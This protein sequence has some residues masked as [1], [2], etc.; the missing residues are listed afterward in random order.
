MIIEKILEHKQKKYRQAPVRSNRASEL[1]HPCLRYLVLNRLKWQEK[2]LPP[3]SKLL[4]YEEGGLHEQKVIRDIQDAG[5]T[6]I[7][8]QRAFEW[9]EYEITGHIDAKVIVQ[10]KVY[11]LEVKTTSPYI[12]RTIQSAKDLYESKHYWVRMYPAQM[13]IYLLLDNKEE[14]IFIFKD[15]SSGELKEIVFKLDYELGE[16]LLQKAEKVNE[17]VKREEIPD[18]IEFDEE[19]C[20]SCGFLHICLPD[21]KREEI[22]LLEDP[23]LL[24]KLDRWYELKQ[25]LKEY[26]ELDKQIKEALKGKERVVLGSFLITGKWV[27]RKTYEVPETEYWQMKIQRISK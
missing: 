4:L 16:E 13:T 2:A 15:K 22:L 20:G 6:V 14:G 9:R 10:E 7:E 24:E 11:P 25:L 27:K 3:I 26:N 12:F 1:G 17:Y 8:Q 18:P 21:V 19:I 23:E 5:F